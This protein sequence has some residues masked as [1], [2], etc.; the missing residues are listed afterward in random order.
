MKCII[1][2][3]KFNDIVKYIGITSNSLNKRKREHISLASK[4]NP[5][6]LIHKAMKKHK[7]YK[8]EKLA[9][10]NSWEEACKFEK[11]LIIHL[12]TYVKNGGY[13]LTMGGE[14]CSQPIRSKE[15]R[16]KKSESQK[17]KI[18]FFK[19]KTH[20]EKSKILIS[21]KK[22]GISAIHLKK[23]IIDNNGNKYNSTIEASRI[24]GIKRS[25]IKESLRRNGALRCGLKFTYA[26]ADHS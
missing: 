18:P 6:Y 3:I 9:I 4:N 24:L 26:E 14:G 2:T 15:W 13:N 25:T 7:N 16:R 5:K 8:F 11:K 22:K 17:L 21:N 19:G 1:Y 20:T 23:P 10:I 12:N